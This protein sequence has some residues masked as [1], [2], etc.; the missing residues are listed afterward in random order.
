MN[1]YVEGANQKDSDAHY[2][3]EKKASM[4]EGMQNVLK[5]GI[6]IKKTLSCKALGCLPSARVQLRR[7]GAEDQREQ[8][9]LRY[10]AVGANK[11]EMQADRCGTREEVP[12]VV[13][14]C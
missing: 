11:W 5:Q 10:H 2:F 13:C 3:E 14:G 4:R 7:R 1:I 8:T 9:V 6:L 12:N